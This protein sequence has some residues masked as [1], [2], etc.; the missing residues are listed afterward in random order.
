M[1]A[2]PKADE[3]DALLTSPLDRPVAV[4]RFPDLSGST[5]LER[6]LSLRDLAGEIRSTTARSK[7]ALP[8]YKLA[9]FGDA[10]SGAGCLRQDHN[11][12]AVTGIEGDY[13]GGEVSLSEAEQ[14]LRKA[15]LAAILYSSPSHTET[16]PRWRVMAPLSHPCAPVARHNLTRRLNGALGG[17]LASESFA[18]SQTYYGGQVRDAAPLDLRLID[19][20]FIDLAPELDADAAGPVAKRVSDAVHIDP[21]GLTL[22]DCRE[23]LSRLPVEYLDGY[24]D[25]WRAVGW[26]LH[27]EFDGSQ[28]AR[29][30]WR[31]ASKRSDRYEGAKTDRAINYYWRKTGG[32]SKGRPVTMRTICEWADHDPVNLRMIDQIFRD[33]MEDF[34][35][36]AP[37]CAVPPPPVTAADDEEEFGVHP[38]TRRLNKRHAVVVVR[39]RTLITTESAC[40]RVDFGDV[41]GLHTYY[42]NDPVAKPGDDEKRVEA[43]QLWLRDPFRRQFPN[44]VTF[45]PAG[46]DPSTLN[47]W[48]GWAVEPDAGAS[49]N[50][51]LAHLRT[52]VCRG[53]EEQLQY[54][55]GWL[56]HMV[57]RPE[58]KPG[59]ALVL[60][61]PKGAGK[62]T[63]ADYLAAMIGRRHAPTVADSRHIVGNFNARLEAALLLH[64]QEG[65][66]AGDRKA[67]GVLKYLVTSDHIEIERK[68]I[69]SINLPSVLR[70][71]ISANAEWVV[72]AS[73]DERRWA[74]F[75]VSGT[76]RGDETYFG[77]LRSEMQRGGA[78]ALL[79][80]LQNH[81]LAGFNVR[82]APETDGL[83]NQK[84]ASLRNIEAWW[85]ESLGR[86]D[87]PGALDPAWLNSVG[88]GR[89][90]LRSD[91]LRW[92]K[93]RRFD[94]EA[95][96]MRQFGARLREMLPA[97]ADKRLRSGQERVRH[98]ILPPLGECRAAF[99]AWLGATVQWDDL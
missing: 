13:D 56:A 27:H 2:Q 87:A 33:E 57:Q 73:Q 40:G 76:R 77:A 20:R 65:S 36:L 26:A 17:V 95:L 93:E 85:L 92:L 79:H 97:L 21:M 78:A 61:G 31:E 81:D 49:C 63:V 64:V 54:L 22:D 50:L 52:V 48:R 88:V 25:G 68:G 60:R 72:P 51:F 39:G 80:Y 29:Q 7:E 59:V 58:Q 89:D 12:L 1:T 98:Y 66:W 19:G 30:V 62:D 74:V 11:V 45:A 6:H 32:P 23:V 24:N 43:S 99:D 34:N 9:A 28:E 44:G 42:A 46:C 75:E 15:G 41:R 38:V 53:D 67:E 14:R 96:D 70:I 8:L 82:R 16:E 10:P 18:L 83:R 86:G 5:K 94:G 55:I 90:A 37:P 4:T 47:L 3:F 69:D 91:Y 84:L 35:P 71:F